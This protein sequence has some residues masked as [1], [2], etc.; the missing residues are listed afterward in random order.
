MIWIWR[1]WLWCFGDVRKEMLTVVSPHPNEC[2]QCH[3]TGLT[4]GTVCQVCSGTGD[5]GQTGGTIIGGSGPVSDYAGTAQ[6][7]PDAPKQELPELH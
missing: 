5:I 1:G 4:S 6:V 3:G 2:E 7:L